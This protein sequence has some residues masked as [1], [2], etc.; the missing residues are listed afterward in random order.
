M[1]VS[2]NF[3]KVNYWAKSSP[4]CVARV[5]D[6]AEGLVLKRFV[7]LFRTSYLNSERMDNLAFDLEELFVEAKEKA[8]AEGAME[9]EEWIR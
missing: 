9:R 7:L 2:I 4:V 6:P 5:L 3:K 8:T 1:Q